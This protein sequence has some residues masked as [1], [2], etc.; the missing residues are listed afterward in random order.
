MASTDV[1]FCRS[2]LQSIPLNAG[3]RSPGPRLFRVTVN[4][5]GLH[6]AMLAVMAVYGGHNPLTRDGIAT[7]VGWR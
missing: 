4:G 7:P 6:P 3:I 5:A 2:A 1:R